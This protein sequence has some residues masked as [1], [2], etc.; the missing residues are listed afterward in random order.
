[1]G[2]VRCVACGRRRVGPGGC[3]ACGGR[4]FEP[5]AVSEPAEIDGVTALHVGHEDAPL[6]LVVARLADVS[7][8]AHASETLE[9]GEQVVV[10]DRGDGGFDAVR[11]PA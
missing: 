2:L 1:M 9:I 8:L 11:E 3:A 4:R 5:T 6:L 7:V 10:R